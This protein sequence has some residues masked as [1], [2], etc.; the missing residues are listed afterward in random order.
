MLEKRL[1]S[2]LIGYE[3]DILTDQEDSERRQIE[4][5]EKTENFVKNLEVDETLGQLLVSENFQSVEEIAQSKPE[6]I[7]K[8]DGIDETT[9]A[10]LI[11]RATESLEK[12]KIEISKKLKDLGVEDSLVNLEGMTQGM[13][14]VL[15]EKNIKKLK[16]FAELSSDELIGGFDEIKGKRIKINGYLEDF[17]LSREEADNL[18]MGARKIV[19]ED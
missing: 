3:I 13:L 1:A 11:S 14:V 5:K 16:D 10:E 19:F 7:H 12:E 15:G 9:A 4:F 8:I 2:K 6:D 17:A 18:I